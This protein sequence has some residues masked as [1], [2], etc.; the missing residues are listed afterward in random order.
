LIIVWRPS[1][2]GDSDQFISAAGGNG[3]DSGNSGDTT[4][5]GTFLFL[6]LLS[7]RILIT[8]GDLN[9]LHRL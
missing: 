6:F 2:S 9:R 1:L 7:I 8:S 5:H 3:G 4:D